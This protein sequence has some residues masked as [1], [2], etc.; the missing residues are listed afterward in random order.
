MRARPRHGAGGR[1]ICISPP[2]SSGSNS[3]PTPATSSARSSFTVGSAA[4]PLQK[5]RCTASSTA[6]QVEGL[7]WWGSCMTLSEKSKFALTCTLF[8]PLARGCVKLAAGRLIFCSTRTSAR[9]HSPSS[10]AWTFR[11][12]GGGSAAGPLFGP[13]PQKRPASFRKVSVLRAERPAPSR[14]TD[15]GLSTRPAPG[16]RSAAPRAASAASSA[17]P[18]PAAGRSL[19]SSGAGVRISAPRLPGASSASA[20]AWAKVWWAPHWTWAHLWL[21]K[22]PRRQR[23][24]HVCSQGREWPMEV[25]PAGPAF[26]EI[27]GSDPRPRPVALKETAPLPA[28]RHCDDFTLL[29]SKPSWP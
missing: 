21:P 2:G 17:A 29:N 6:S 8:L 5:A 3:S 7:S 25:V 28:P 10:T 9:L 23:R 22:G 4:D 14:S 16:G 15:F 19:S 24:G 18:A 26:A 12:E 1:P 20:E 27:S 13:I 11:G